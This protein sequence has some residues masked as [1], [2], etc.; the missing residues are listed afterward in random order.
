MNSDPN[1]LSGRMFPDFSHPALVVDAEDTANDAD[2]LLGQTTNSVTFA[3]VIKSVGEFYGTIEE[4][5][6]SRSFPHLGKS[7]LM[8][9]GEFWTLNTLEWPSDAADCSVCSLS[10]ILETW[11]DWGQRHP[12]ATY[13]E[14]LDYISKFYLSANACLGIKRRAEMRG[15]KLPQQLQDALRAVVINGHHETKQI[16]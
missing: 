2:Q 1:I 8:V 12:G 4:Q 15:R 14:W 16:T 11:E 5:T 6:S 3:E 7:G 9:R 10:E 13:Q